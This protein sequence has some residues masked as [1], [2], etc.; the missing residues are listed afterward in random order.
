V[1]VLYD[2]ADPSVADIDTFR[3]GWLSLLAALAGLGF[4]VV[5]IIQAV[6]HR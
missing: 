3:G 1:R 6:R 5:P 2:P 4:T